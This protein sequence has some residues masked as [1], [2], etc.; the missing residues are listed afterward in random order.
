MNLD[1]LGKL[2]RWL[3][4][5]VPANKPFSL[6]LHYEAF[7][8][9]LQAVFLS[10]PQNNHLG[11]DTKVHRED[12]CCCKNQ[13]TVPSFVLH[14]HSWRMLFGEHVPFSMSNENSQA[15]RYSADDRHKKLEELKELLL[16]KLA[17]VTVEGE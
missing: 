5:A 4:A 1:F 15:F 2:I 12:V 10:Y 9:F 6:Y 3:K 7:L 16:S 11:S 17:T 14:L 13:S 8:F